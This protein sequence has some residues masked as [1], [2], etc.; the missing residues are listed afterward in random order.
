MH[1]YMLARFSVQLQVPA[2]M[3]PDREV[4]RPSFNHH[5]ICQAVWQ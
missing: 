1:A 4:I 2:T 5:D 3:N